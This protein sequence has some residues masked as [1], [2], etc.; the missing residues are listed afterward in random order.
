MWQRPCSAGQRGHFGRVPLCGM[1]SSDS[2]GSCRPS[3]EAPAQCTP[4]CPPSGRRAML[5]RS[6]STIAGSEESVRAPST[7]TG[8]LQAFDPCCGGSRKPRYSQHTGLN[9]SFLGDTANCDEH[10]K[11][12]ASCFPTFS[13]PTIITSQ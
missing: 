1:S 10:L 11:F 3:L 5:W 2:S 6:V 8:P 4:P 13:Y 12:Y 9:F 7:V